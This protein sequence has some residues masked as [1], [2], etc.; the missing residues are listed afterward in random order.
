MAMTVAPDDAPEWATDP[1]QLW[2]AVELAEK[3]KD[4]Q[5]ARDYRIPVPLGL[6][7][8]RAGRLAEKLARFIMSELGTP[9]SVG[10]H[11]DAD[12]DALGQVKPP[13]KQGYHAHLYFPSRPL[14]VSSPEV[15]GTGTGMATATFGA[16]HPMLASKA[17]GRGMVETFNRVWAEL[18]TEAAADAGIHAQ[19]DHR[20]YE[21]MGLDLAPQPTL[22]AGAVALERKGFWT[23]KGDAVRD[24]VVASK[25]YE[26]AH[27]EVV[28][29]QQAAAVADVAR[30]RS[31]GDKT[32]AEAGHPSVPDTERGLAHHEV[33]ASSRASTDQPD[34]VLS[35]LAPDTPLLGRFQA[36]A[37]RPS[38]EDGAR[39][40]QVLR[41]V[42]V[43]QRALLVIRELTDRLVDAEGRA[44]RAKAAELE[45]RY[46]L[47]QARRHRAAAT[48]RADNWAKAHPFRMR[49]GKLVGRRP[50]AWRDLSHDI[51]FHQKGVQA[52]KDI[53]A[54]QAFEVTA[55]QGKV[56][57]IKNRVTTARGR[58]RTAAAG[59]GQL[60]PDYLPPLLAVLSPEQ[61]IELEPTL[62]GFDLPTV[63][64]AV[65]LDEQLAYRPPLPRL[66]R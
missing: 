35:A 11:R 25:A 6:D 62:A 19:Y 21:R 8:Q 43:I 54:K 7:D 53:V 58:L 10:L 66:G 56:G 24:I 46:E 41:L 40:A 61:R 60:G 32:E 45:A 47:D 28:A 29:V 65:R 3:R 36:L 27:A 14:V 55:R 34:L 50:A 31:A 33:P 4:S 5:V 13:E 42:R 2:N 52:T 44:R 18:S 37:P 16:R 17:L 63:P 64:V 9:V 1:G 30:E 48:A 22:G 57:A 38:P 51:R 59:L 23:R 49:A 12:A 15:E 20:S 26:L 39:W